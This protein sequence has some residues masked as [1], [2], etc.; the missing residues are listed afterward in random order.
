MGLHNFSYWMS[1]LFE[2]LLLGYTS[3][4]GF[5]VFPLMFMGVIGYVY[6]KNQSV[7]A[8]A[9]VILLIVTVFGGSL[10]K[11]P[12]LVILLWIMVSLALTSLLLVWLSK[13][14]QS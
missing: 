14:R 3:A 8:G 13:R 9:V 11:V 7:T 5:F 2:Q 10:A 12:E 1:H 4:I 6:L